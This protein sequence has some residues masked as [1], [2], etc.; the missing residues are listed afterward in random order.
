MALE[1][2]DVGNPQWVTLTV[3]SQCTE[4]KSL[5]W[6]CE[7]PSG[8]FQLAHQSRCLRGDGRKSPAQ[9]CG[10][11]QALM[12]S[13]ACCLLAAVPHCSPG[14]LTA[15]GLPITVFLQNSPS[16]PGSPFH[17]NP[18]QQGLRRQRG[19][20]MTRVLP[21]TNPLPKTFVGG[22]WRRGRLAS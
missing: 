5:D 22:R 14:P 8:C 3:R 17:Q 1:A 15:Q 6:V 4:W 18:H 21:A 13:A 2:E 11:S 7:C 20:M 12:S 9:S 10:L 16:T 19:K